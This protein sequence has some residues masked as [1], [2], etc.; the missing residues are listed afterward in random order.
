MLETRAV[1]CRNGKARDL[2]VDHKPND[3]K[4]EDRIRKLGGFV[5]WDGYKDEN[6]LR[7]QAMVATA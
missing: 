5:F 7:S 2:T 4:E 3:P 1:L 6:G